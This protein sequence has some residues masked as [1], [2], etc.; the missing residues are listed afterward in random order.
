MEITNI[1]KY[2]NNKIQCVRNTKIAEKFNSR[3][4]RIGFHRSYPEYLNKINMYKSFSSI[5]DAHIIIPSR[6]LALAT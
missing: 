6:F 4:H 5:T 1:Q 2:K 3:K